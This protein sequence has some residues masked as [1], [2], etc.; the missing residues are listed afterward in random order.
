VK[1]IALALALTIAPIAVVSPV[2]ASQPWLCPKYTAEIKKTFPRKDWRTMDRIMH[3]E[4]KC[5]RKA[6]GWNHYKGMSHKDC[7]DNGRYH[8][9]KRCKAVRTWDVGLFQINSSW[10]TITT[11]LCG[12]NTRSTVLMRSSC[13]FRVAKWLYENGG[14]VHWQGTSTR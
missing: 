10:F 3:R 5:I 12:K 8:N 11:Q 13:N 2:E 7:K 4:S 1:R 6:V 9:R 14:L